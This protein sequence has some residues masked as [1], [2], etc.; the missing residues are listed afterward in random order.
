MSSIFP[1]DDLAIITS[2]VVPGS[3]CFSRNEHFGS[4]I[5]IHGEG[6]GPNRRNLIV[7]DGQS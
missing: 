6:V 4:L 1:L 5:E 3:C 7:C 2:I